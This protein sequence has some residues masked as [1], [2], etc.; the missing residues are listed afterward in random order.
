MIRVLFVCHGNICRS[1]MA[2][3]L[4]KD[5]VKKKNIADKFYIESAGTSSEEKGNPVHVGTKRILSKLDIDC[6]T[7]RA[8][9]IKMQDYQNFDYIICM[10]QYNKINLLRLFDYDKNNKVHLLMEY[11]DSSK[12]VADPWY[13]GNFD[14]TYIDIKNGLEGFIKYLNF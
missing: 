2:E 1:T 12:D 7:K 11:T 14:Q 6:S 13:S 4:F 5:M 8:R 10:D 3:F 9:Q